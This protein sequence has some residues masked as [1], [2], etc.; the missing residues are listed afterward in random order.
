MLYDE[1]EVPNTP[2]ELIRQLTQKDSIPEF[3]DFA[4]AKLNSPNT[5][6]IL[7]ISILS[8]PDEK[9]PSLANF[10][11][12]RLHHKQEPSTPLLAFYIAQSMLGDALH[13]LEHFAPFP[14]LDGVQPEDDE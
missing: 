3:L 1:D 7:M 9:N 2:E 11:D 6:A 12:L 4:R 8:N 14:T 13:N 5:H 10:M